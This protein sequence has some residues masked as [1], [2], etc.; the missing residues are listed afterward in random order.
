MLLGIVA[1]G[2]LEPVEPED[3]DALF[4]DVLL[5]FDATGEAND[6]TI[7]DHSPFKR[8]LTPVGTARI[9]DEYLEMDGNEDWVTAADSDAWRFYNGANVDFTIECFGVVFDEQAVDTNGNGQPLV[10]KYDA[11][12]PATN[13][14]EWYFAVSAANL[15]A[16]ISTA[17]TSVNFSMP[18]AWSPVLGQEYDLTLERT[19]TTYRLYIDGEVVA[20]D[21]NAGVIFNG[22]SPIAIGSRNTRAGGAGDRDDFNGRMRAVR[23]TQAA[24]YSGDYTVP[25]LPLAKV[26]PDGFVGDSWSTTDHGPGLTWSNDYR[27][28]LRPNSGNDS[29]NYANAARSTRGRS[30]G[31]VYFEATLS[32]DGNQWSGFFGIL[33]SSATLDSTTPTATSAP[34]NADC[35]IIEPSG[36]GGV[37]YMQLW[38]QG[39]PVV[40]YTPE[41]PDDAVTG[42]AVDFDLGKIW[43]RNQGNW[44]LGSLVGGATSATFDEDDPTFTFTPGDEWKIYG[45][46]PFNLTQV[47]LNPGPTFANDPPPG[48]GYW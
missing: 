44:L 35:I 39:D 36:G 8:P 7:L 41:A 30:T 9:L 47:T 6:A 32:R 43:F 40:T 31:K 20:T 26:G 16:G 33:K 2:A 10:T 5:L 45:E 28:I 21:D 19:G 15:S 23:I 12:S 22:S 48:F 18:F 14:R 37:A 3:Q 42:I 38:R 1:G 46:S 34:L 11:F 27:T 29:P 13:Q 4:A 17:G 25:A 24:R